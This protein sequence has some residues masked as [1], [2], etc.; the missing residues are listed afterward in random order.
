VT[1]SRP[2]KSALPST[3]KVQETVTLPEPRLFLALTQVCRQLRAEFLPIYR[4]RNTVHVHYL[5]FQAYLDTFACPI[6]SDP[7]SVAGNIAIDLGHDLHDPADAEYIDILPTLMLCKNAPTF[8]LQRGLRYSCNCC[9]PERWEFEDDVYESLFN[10]SKHDR[11]RTYLD[12]AVCAVNLLKEG[13]LAFKIYEQNWE[14]W[15]QDWTAGSSGGSE[16]EMMR[17]CADLGF[18]YDRAHEVIYFE[19]CE[20]A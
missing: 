20:A 2:R 8:T 11:L 15:M 5:D 14:V 12:K 17:W 16:P 4:S 10:F 1:L 9:L 6:T 19:R 3:Q 18:C 7:A 13:F